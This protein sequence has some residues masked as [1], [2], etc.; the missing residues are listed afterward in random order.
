MTRKISPNDKE[1]VTRPRHRRKRA[2]RSL[3]ARLKFW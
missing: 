2:K 1:R 3:L